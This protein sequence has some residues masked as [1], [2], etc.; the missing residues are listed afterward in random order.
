MWLWSTFV[1]KDD[2]F[3]QHTTNMELAE[4]ERDVNPSCFMSAHVC[5]LGYEESSSLKPPPGKAKSTQLLEQFL[6]DGFITTTEP[7]TINLPDG[8]KN[9]CPPPWGVLGG[10][11]LSP[12]SLGYVEG[13]ARATTLLALLLFIKKEGVDLYANNPVLFQSVRDIKV[14]RLRGKGMLEDALMNMKMSVRGSIRTANNVL[15]VAVIVANL[16]KAGA[17]SISTFVSKHHARSGQ[18]SK[19]TG[20]RA[21]SLR[22]LFESLP[23]APLES[24]LAHAEELTWEGCMWSDDNLANRKLYP[25]FAFPAKNKTWAPMLR[26]TDASTQLCIERLQGAHTRSPKHLRKKLE[27][28]QL[29]NYSLRAAA[30]LGLADLFLS[31][32]P[33]P[34]K[35][36]LEEWTHAWERGSHQ[37]DMEVQAAV[38]EQHEQF[39]PTKHIPTFKRILDQHLQSAPLVV[40]VEE[41]AKLKVDEFALL[42]KQLDYDVSVYQTWQRKCQTVK[43]ARFFKEQ[44]SGFTNAVLQQPPLWFSPQCLNPFIRLYYPHPQ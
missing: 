43:G 8:L 26:T 30:V 12:R 33:V 34:Q 27:A 28:S 20:K 39:D 16:Q 44:D 23:R 42:I 29:E 2:I 19:I 41:S 24:I 3:Y 21:A 25:G 36:A 22:L 18:S 10:S 1:E 17:R 38:M 15:Q 35:D 13:H 11:A 40:G 14:I 7:P 37:V 32:V 6:L 5:T 31:Q 4:T 9:T